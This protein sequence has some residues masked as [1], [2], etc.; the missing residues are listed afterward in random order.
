MVAIELPGRSDRP[1]ADPLYRSVVAVTLATCRVMAW[2]VDVRG[3]E[4][5]P[6]SGA[7]I[8]ASNH[9]GPMD[10]VFVGLAGHRRGRLVRFVAM[11]EAFDHWLSGPLLRGMRHI[12][13]D[14]QA[15]P[16][17]GYRHAARALEHGEVVGI[18]PEGRI[19]RTA[20]PGP[21]KTGAARLAVET[22]APLIPIAVSGTQHLLARGAARRFPRRVDLRVSVG[23]PLDVDHRADPRDL[24]AALMARIERLCAATGGQSVP[25]LP[26]RVGS[27]VSPSG[28]PAPR[29]RREAGGMPA[30]RLA[31]R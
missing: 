9:I 1:P 8:L 13:V 5:I 25:A 28:A 15:N 24:T 31:T 7:A 30:G 3:D 23:A 21:G 27:L 22:G 4:H 14:R 19:I 10:F 16:A 2:R 18:H 26:W 20:R 17:A 6:A 11:Q 12:P 29:A